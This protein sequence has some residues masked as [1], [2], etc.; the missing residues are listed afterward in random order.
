M[1]S[2]ELINLFAVPLSFFI[3][4]FS[5]LLLQWILVNLISRHLGAI[6]FRHPLLFRA[7]NWW[8]VFIHELS[9]AITAIATFNKVK[10]F[11]VTSNGGY[12]IH[13]SS[14]R[15]GFFRWLAVQFISASPSFVPPVIAALLLK[16]LGHIDFPAIVLDAVSPEPVSIIS[17]LY[18]GLIPDFAG[19]VGWLLINLNYTGIENLLLLLFLA[20][21]FSAAKPSSIE[22]GKNMKGDMQSLTEMFVRFPLYTILFLLLCIASFW[23]LMKYYFPLFLTVLTFL[24]LLPVLSIFGLVINYLFI[25]LVNGLDNSSTLHILIALSASILAYILMTHYTGKQYLVNMTGI[26]VLAGLLKVL[27]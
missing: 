20:F 4:V 2:R 11:K 1:P 17:A 16:Y 25:R 3:V 27:R 5:I 21:S 10:G 6:Y 9:H 15:F 14:G 26:L 12:V 22:K 24:V 18:L 8:G 23:I 7:M 19:K 13:E